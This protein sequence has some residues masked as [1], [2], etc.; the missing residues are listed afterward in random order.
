MKL[1]GPAK[2]LG[3]LLACG[4]ALHGCAR[5]TPEAPT[6]VALPAV[7]VK[8]TALVPPPVPLSADVARAEG[9]ALVARAGLTSGYVDEAGFLRAKAVGLTEEKTMSLLEALVRPCLTATDAERTACKELGA[10]VNG[11]DVLVSSLLGV[12]GN[13]IPPSSASGASRPSVRLLVRLEARGVWGATT[14]LRTVLKKRTEAA[15]GP[16]SPPTASEIASA[17]ASLQGFVVVDGPSSQSRSSA[18]RVHAPTPT[19]LA[20]L[21]YFYAAIAEQGPE[22]GLVREDHTSPAKPPDDALVLE[23]KRQAGQMQTALLDGD[24]ET[25]AKLADAY[26]ASLGYPRPIRVREDG[27]VRWGGEGFSYV[28]RDAARSHELLGHDKEAT[29]LNRRAQPG[30]GMCGTSAATHK[31]DQKRAVLRATERTTG[32]R[33]ALADR[34]YGLDRDPWTGPARLTRAGFDVERLYRGA[35]LTGNRDDRAILETAFAAARRA[36]N[37]VGADALDRLARLGTEDW[38]TR[39]RAIEGYADTARKGALD[40]L[41]ALAERGSVP[42][43]TRAIQTLGNLVQDRGYDPCNKAE[44]RGWGVGSS[45]TT[46]TSVMHVCE[47]RLDRREQSRVVARLGALA[48]SSEV[49]LRAAVAAALGKTGVPAAKPFLV[50]LEKDRSQ[51]VGQI[52]TSVDSA[53]PVCGPDFPVRRAAQAA[54]AD[55]AS[56]DR[57]RHELER[58]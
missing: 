4:I 16:C 9:K 58:E 1:F 12:L 44:R 33:A 39:V 18:W 41:L 5:P 19:E 7:K 28:L 45:E 57:N 2:E 30:G 52:C 24:I 29:E 26:L 17:S 50:A 11:I 56:A 21:A 53:P 13:A 3:C 43:R 35:L 6:V 49:V 8:P 54:L 55:L 37:S 15:L 36:G 27:D 46:V 23:R 42:S 20:D 34:L 32:C 48:G 51:A 22:V 14:A 25:H 38:A 31:I 47:G 10:G 40:K